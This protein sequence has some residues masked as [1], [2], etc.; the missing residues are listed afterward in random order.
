MDQDSNTVSLTCFSDVLC[1]W[2]YV[3]EV[4]LDEVKAQFGAQVEINHRF[5][6]VFGNTQQKIGEGWAQRGGFA[7][8][9]AHAI[10]VVERFEHVNIHHDIWVGARPASSTPA[11]LVLKAVQRACPAS[12]DDVMRGIRR[13]FFAECRDIA[14]RDVLDSILEEQGVSVQACREVIDSGQAFA[15][16]EADA[17][18]RTELKVPGSPTYILDNGRQRLFGNVGYRVIEANIRELLRSP[19]A[20][21]ACW[22]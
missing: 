6:S 18:D 15:D 7:G 1:I 5:C 2:S 9:A 16:L 4:R 13:A 19:A 20:G 10:D 11:H 8:F 22:C 14:R 21:M 3:S 12:T 17:H